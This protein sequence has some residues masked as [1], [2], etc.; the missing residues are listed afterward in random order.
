MDVPVVKCVK[1]KLKTCPDYATR[2][3]FVLMLWNLVKTTIHS[4]AEK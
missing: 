4:G 3:V 2:Q 1:R